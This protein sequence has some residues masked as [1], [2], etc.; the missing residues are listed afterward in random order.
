[1][2]ALYCRTG[3]SRCDNSRG[4]HGPASAYLT[5]S[6]TS[7]NGFL[8]PAGIW[9][10]KSDFHEQT[11]ISFTISRQGRWLDDVEFN[12][13]VLNNG[14][15]G[16][17]LHHEFYGMNSEDNASETSWSRPLKYHGVH[18]MQCHARTT[19]GKQW[20]NWCCPVCFASSLKYTRRWLELF[21][22]C[23]DPSVIN[24]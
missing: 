19:D 14:H 3:N 1:D 17:T 10:V 15:V 18:L 4:D 12:W 23:V 6:V 13:R 2:G 8:N 22:T 9:V 5:G 7:A 21:P 16:D 20:A 11:K 24:I